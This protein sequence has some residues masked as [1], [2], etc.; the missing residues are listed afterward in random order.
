MNSSYADRHLQPEEG[1]HEQQLETDGVGW[2]TKLNLGM[3]SVGCFGAQLDNCVHIFAMEYRKMF[4][5]VSF[6]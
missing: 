1:A 6:P 2:K 4:F 5:P 3:I